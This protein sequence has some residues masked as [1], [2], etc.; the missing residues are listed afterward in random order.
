MTYIKKGTAPDNTARDLEIYNK[1]MFGKK[2][3]KIAEEYKLTHSR[4]RMICEKQER[5]KAF[6]LRQEAEITEANSGITLYK[7]LRDLPNLSLV[8][9]ANCFKNADINTLE[10]VLSITEEYNGKG[11]LVGYNFN[12]KHINNLGVVSVEEIDKVLSKNNLQRKQIEFVS[13][14]DQTI[15]ALKEI[16]REIRRVNQAAG[17]TI[18]NPAATDALEQLLKEH[19]VLTSIVN[20]GCM[21]M[22]VGKQ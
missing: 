13:Q 20:D 10:D 5:I 22:T 14:E 2:F 6:H 19:G 4:I 21:F 15:E 16:R 11:N 9:I 18:F 8:R 3:S 12:G 17:Q 7:L 1:H